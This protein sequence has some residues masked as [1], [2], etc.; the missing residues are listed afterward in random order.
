MRI[1]LLLLLALALTACVTSHG[2]NFNET[3]VQDLRPGMTEQE[4]TQA[5]GGKPGM[6]KYEMDGSYVAAWQFVKTNPL[7]FKTESKGAYLQF[8]KNK[9]F[10]RVVE[11]GKLTNE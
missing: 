7:T 9:K 2:N 6:R 4:V 8:D 1:V 3:L 11:F 10:V 5:L